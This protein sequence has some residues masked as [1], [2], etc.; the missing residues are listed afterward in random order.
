MLEG[1]YVG[2][3]PPLAL[4]V[5][6][7]F[8]RFVYVCSCYARDAKRKRRWPPPFRLASS[9]LFFL[10]EVDICVFIDFSIS[11]SKFLKFLLLVVIVWLRYC[12]YWVEFTWDRFLVLTLYVVVEGLYNLGYQ[13]EYY[14]CWT[15]DYLSHLIWIIG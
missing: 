1:N 9:I 4:Q 10:T 5:F 12:W 14:C 11:I 8:F 6:D 13:D 15:F 7:G 2:P 3:F